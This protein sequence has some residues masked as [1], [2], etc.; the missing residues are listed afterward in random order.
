MNSARILTLSL[1]LTSCDGGMFGTGD[2]GIDIDTGDIASEEQATGEDN[3]SPEN[4]ESGGSD[5]TNASGQVPESLI[6]SVPTTGDTEARIR[7][8]NFSNTVLT[9]SPSF[10][11]TSTVSP[12]TVSS[13]LIVPASTDRIELLDESGE[14]VAVFDPVALIAGSQTG[15]LVRTDNDDNG[16]DV[17]TFPGQADTGNDG[18]AQV[19]L[20]LVSGEDTG[21]TVL[22]PAGNNPATAEALLPAA[23]IESPIGDY[24]TTLPGDFILTSLIVSD[25]V[26]TL[27]PD[28]SY[29]LVVDPD[30]LDNTLRLIN[31][32]DLD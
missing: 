13:A 4:L 23:S 5:A 15:V 10:T 14:P 8:F 20:V 32:S 17:M 3:V 28:T 11:E 16:V 24:V 26:I 7:V 19:R 25:T 31:E 6:N 2:P 30:D 1:I 29:S 18:T 21:Q 22:S 9:V 12:A 27:E